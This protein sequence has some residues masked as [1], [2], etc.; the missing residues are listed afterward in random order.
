[1]ND[2]YL[3]RRAD[4]DRVIEVGFEAMIGMDSLGF[5]TLPDGVTARRCQHLEA[6]AL[7]AKTG[8]V[9]EL[10]KPIVSD[11]LGFTFHQLD[12]FEL[13][14][15]K[16]GFVGTEFKPDPL[17]PGFFQVRFTSQAEKDRYAK[18]RG[19]FEKNSRNGGGTPPSEQQV[20]KMRA[21]ILEKYPVQK[22]SENSASAI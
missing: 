21:K 6:P 19:Q 2:K 8:A 17:V 3:F 13:D 10:N 14:R 11:S 9:K 15:Q 22:K 5:I 1:M 20:E 4:N 7:R 18:H 12:D 16:N